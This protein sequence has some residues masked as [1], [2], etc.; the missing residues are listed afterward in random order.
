MVE[1]NPGSAWGAAFVY[2]VAVATIELPSYH[3]T[4][5]GRGLLP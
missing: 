4:A 2:Q 1:E 5:A 3:G